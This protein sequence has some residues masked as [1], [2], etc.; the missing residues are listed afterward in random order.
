MQLKKKECD[1][2]E[3]GRMSKNKG[4]ARAEKERE[5]DII[6]LHAAKS[7]AGGCVF[8]AG[9]NIRIAEANYKCGVRRIRRKR[10]C[11]EFRINIAELKIHSNRMIRGIKSWPGFWG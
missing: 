2:A 10:G 11:S 3:R 8:S 5:N 1:T 7:F 6:T 9:F 4:G